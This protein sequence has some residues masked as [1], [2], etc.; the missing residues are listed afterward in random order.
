MDPNN[1]TGTTLAPGASCTFYLK[2]NFESYATTTTE[3]LNVTL[4]YTLNN[5]LF[6]NDSNAISS[7][8]FTIY[9]VTNLYAAQVNGY[10][11]IFN[12]NGSTNFY[13][14]SFNDPINTSATDTSNYGFLYL[15]G[16]NGIY[17]VGA[18]SSNESSSASIS[19]GTFSGAINN[20]FTFSS[21][22]YSIASTPNNSAVWTY[23]LSS[24]TWATSA[25][26]SLNTE[27]RPNANA[28]SPGGVFYFASSNQ[29]FICSTSSSSTTTSNCLADGV[30]TN[31]SP[32]SPGTVNA[33]AFPN[34]GSSPFTGLYIGGSGGLFAE[35]GTI[36]APLNS[37]N[38]WVPV[39]V[40]TGSGQTPLSYPIT[41]MTVYNNNL[42]AGDNQGNIWYVPSAYP[43]NGG[44]PVAS[45]VAN[46]S[47]P[48]SAMT[49]DTIGG[50]LYFAT[51]TGYSSTLYGCNVFSTPSSCTP[52]ANSMTLYPVVSLSIASQLAN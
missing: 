43:A 26:F 48:I 36:T 29:I 1:C 41:A 35:S 25:I 3:A 7:S 19:P 22:L 12:V 20:L 17:P 27:I 16:N 6:N 28:I 39:T 8:S 50:I 23:N 47:N 9:E 42:Y 24:R 52:E 32:T 46:V 49:A 31:L 11:G 33:L 5:N 37:L 38:T 4:N 18:E 45:L 2:I 40:E 13:A 44:T 21:N 14:E 51:T 15:G 34:S 10:A 30:V